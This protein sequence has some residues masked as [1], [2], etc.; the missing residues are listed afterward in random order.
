MH[1]IRRVIS[2]AADVVQSVVRS[3]AVAAVYLRAAEQVL[4]RT[5]DAPGCC[6]AWEPALAARGCCQL[7][8][9]EA[10]QAGQAGGNTVSH[11][12]QLYALKTCWKHRFKYGI[13]PAAT[14]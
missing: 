8:A 2:R 13:V 10:R 5:A 11:L 12:L 3:T 14:L 9:S 6:S 1:T 7:P 4:L